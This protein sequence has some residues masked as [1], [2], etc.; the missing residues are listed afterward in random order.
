MRFYEHEAKRILRDRGTPVPPGRLASS[1][2]G[3]V[4]AALRT[5]Y[6]VVLKGQVL[7]G[8][9]LRAGA[10]RTVTYAR[11]ARRAAQEILATPVRG[12]RPKALLLE[13]RAPVEQEY[14]LAV[15]YDTTARQ[16]VLV[17]SDRGGVEIEEV[18]AEAPERV[19]RR[20]FSPPPLRR[21][22]GPRL[23]GGPGAERRRWR[24][25]RPYWRPWPGPSWSWT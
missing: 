9:R 22:R 24:A 25:S 21:L 5:G 6:P 13:A 11:E 16:P 2:A 17:A 4:R 19:S 14:Y 12:Q 7:T 20:P 1:A 18:A 15:T 3:A 8:G 10:V 23:P